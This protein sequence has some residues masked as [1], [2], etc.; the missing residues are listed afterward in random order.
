MRVNKAEGERLDAAAEAAWVEGIIG[1]DGPAMQIGGEG[2]TPGY[3]NN[4]GKPNPKSVQNGAYGAGP[5]K[6][7]EEM[8]AWREEGSLAGMKLS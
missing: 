4:E 1:G 3:Y 8:D 6:F 5:V 7:F 2:C